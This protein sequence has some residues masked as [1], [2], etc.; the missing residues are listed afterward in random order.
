MVT[1]ARELL[2]QERMFSLHGRRL[3][4]SFSILYLGILRR[5]ELVNDVT[6]FLA[7]FG[8]VG[9][10]LTQKNMILFNP[11]TRVSGRMNDF[12]VYLEQYEK[13]IFIQFSFNKYFI[14]FINSLCSY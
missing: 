12:I 8:L 2:C 10:F 6:I 1:L 7:L 13:N 3:M 4:N 11:Y 5:N 9:S 14:I